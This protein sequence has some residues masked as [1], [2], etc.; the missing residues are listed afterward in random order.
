MNPLLNLLGSGWTPGADVNCWSTRPD[1]RRFPFADVRADGNGNF[2]L[3]APISGN[4]SSAPY[5]SE[6]PGVWAVTCR[7]PATGETALTNA[8]V[9]ALTLDP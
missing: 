1:G 7:V 3:D 4:D 8:M 9:H 5:A 6:E 2:A